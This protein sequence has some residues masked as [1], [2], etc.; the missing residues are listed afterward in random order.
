MQGVCNCT[1]LNT[2]SVTQNTYYIY[3]NSK[4]LLIFS[5]KTE[6]FHYYPSF[7]SSEIKYRFANLL[8]IC[9]LLCP[10]SSQV[11]L[12]QTILLLEF[13]TKQ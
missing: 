9:E 5:S 2:S 4:P 10:W 1:E 7:V 8:W 12:P 11:H 13:G 6:F 3:I